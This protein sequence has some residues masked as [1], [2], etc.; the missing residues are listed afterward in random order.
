MLKKFR[1]FV[2]SHN[3]RSFWK[4]FA[5]MILAVTIMS[6]GASCYYQSNLGADPYSALVNSE[7]ILMNITVGQVTYINNGLLLIFMLFFGRKYIHVGTLVFTFG[8]GVL[9]D[10]FNRLISTCFPPTEL[11]MQILCLTSGLV[12]FSVGIA[13]YVIADLGINGI[14]CMALVFSRKTGCNL[15]WVRVG[16]DLLFVL[17]AVCIGLV[18]KATIF[19]DIIGVG[20]LV[21]A[22]GTG[23]IMKGFINLTGS[24]FDRWFGPL[25]KEAVPADRS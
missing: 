5:I 19:G 14:E 12:C 17:L 9:I 21:G 10:L 23:I 6:F 3:P 1:K 22:V 25:R 8:T 7:H 18:A 2:L 15:R 4:R 16:E 20:T 13:L 24:K 11:W